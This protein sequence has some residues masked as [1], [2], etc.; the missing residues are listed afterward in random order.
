VNLEIQS[1]QVIKKKQQKQNK[2]Q[3]NRQTNK[4]TKNKTK[5]NHIKKK[6]FQNKSI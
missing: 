5:Q 1:Y 3:T 6:Y 2:K 4:Q